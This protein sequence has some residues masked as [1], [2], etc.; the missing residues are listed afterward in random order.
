MIVIDQVSKKF[1]PITALDTVSLTVSKGQV[2]GLLGQNGAGKS[3]LLNI[4]SGY[5]P[6]SSG[7]V[8]I[9]ESD[10]LLSPMKAKASIGYLPETPPVY[11]E[12]TVKEYLRFCC[13][14]K[15]VLKSDQAEHIDEI[16]ELTGLKD[17]QSRLIANLSKGYRQRTGLAQALCGG[18]ELL[19]LDE[20]TSG[21]DPS[22]VVE[23]RNTIQALSRKHTIIFSSHILSEVQSICQRIVVLHQGRLVLDHDLSGNDAKD[24][25]FHLC[26]A[27]DKEK[28]I[29]AIRSLPSVTRVKLLPVQGDSCAMNVFTKR[30]LPFEH[31]LFSLLSGLQAPILELSPMKDSIEE[32]FMRITSSKN[33]TGASS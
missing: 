19:L 21:F 24:K 1:G 22:Q 27:A 29:P 26:V 4:L 2:L 28:L 15:G 25:R 31:E 6:A 13:N 8:L 16:S 5:L 11:P 10:M 17:I 20:P 23:F 9:N 14:L 3:T 7:R 33:G 18:P 32:V 30:D 12:M